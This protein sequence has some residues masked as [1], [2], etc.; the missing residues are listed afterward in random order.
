MHSF[1]LE[2]LENSCYS[3]DTLIQPFFFFFPQT[4][5]LAPKPDNLE[6]PGLLC[7]NH[8]ISEKEVITLPRT[9][10]NVS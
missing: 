5:V 4:Q 2:K 7:H 6:G 1:E 9:V 3:T 8:N 10:S